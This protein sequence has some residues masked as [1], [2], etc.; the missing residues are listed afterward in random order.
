MGRGDHSGTFS[1]QN[2]AVLDNAGTL[3]VTGDGLL[4]NDSGAATFNNSGTFAKSAGIGTTLIDR[5]GAGPF[6]VNNTGTL[7]VQ[8]GTLQ[9]GGGVVFNHDGVVNV[10]SGKFFTLTS[11]TGAGVGDYVL[12]GT[13]QVNFNSGTQ[14]FNA[15]ADI[16][17]AGLFNVNGGALTVAA[18]LSADDLALT[19]GTIDGVGALTVDNSFAWSGGT[20]SGAGTTTVVPGATLAISGA[21]P[22]LHQRTF[23]QQS[24]SGSWGGSGTFSLQ[25][26]AVLNNAGT[27]TVTGD[28]LLRND[29]GAA[30]F[31]NSG[32]F[33]KNTGTGQTTV[34][35]TGAGPFTIS[36]TGTLDVQSGTLQVGGNAVFNHDGVVNVASGAMFALNSVSGAGT[37]DYVLTGTGQR[38]ELL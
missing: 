4:R 19:T 8:S 31:N 3:T 6:T 28:G 21:N 36:N 7:D 10:A 24:T 27:L 9:V 23:N 1:L 37:G 35:R 11:V 26:G 20:M 30:T 22:I 5:T 34:D 33:R 17:G 14:T 16:S 29:S 2:G 13:G 15:G 18:A 32:T 12:A 25:N 38:S